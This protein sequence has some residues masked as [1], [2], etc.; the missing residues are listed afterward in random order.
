MKK[1]RSGIPM[2]LVYEVGK[3]N[4]WLSESEKRETPSKIKQITVVID[5]GNGIQHNWQWKKVIAYNWPTPEEMWECAGSEYLARSLKEYDR[6]EKEEILEN[7]YYSEEDKAYFRSLPVE[8]RRAR[9]R[10][11]IATGRNR[12]AGCEKAWATRRG[13]NGEGIPVEGPAG[14][15][16]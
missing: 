14:E 11:I 16:S 10:Q 4:P 7:P 12:S 5:L 2:R 9:I 1:D 3:D 6:Y 15:G 13:K 8:E